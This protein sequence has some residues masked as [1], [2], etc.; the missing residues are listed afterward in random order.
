MQE[1]AYNKN[2]QNIARM[3]LQTIL[4]KLNFKI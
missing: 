3:Y 4:Q 1:F 2:L